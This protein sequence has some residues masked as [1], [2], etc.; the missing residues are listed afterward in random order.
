MDFSSEVRKW[1]CVIRETGPAQPQCLPVPFQ[2]QWVDFLP[3]GEAPGRIVE[4][5]TASV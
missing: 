1:L 4:L 3:Q 2:E 5:H